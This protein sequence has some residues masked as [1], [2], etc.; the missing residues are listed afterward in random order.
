MSALK[1]PSIAR[2]GMSE[3]NTMPLW[4][5]GT[6]I[7]KANEKFF[8]FLRSSVDFLGLLRGL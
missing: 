1:K 4:N 5:S 2:L 8:P 7:V 6:M 3:R